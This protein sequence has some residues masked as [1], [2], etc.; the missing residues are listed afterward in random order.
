MFNFLI[1]SVYS[2]EVDVVNVES[3]KKMKNSDQ[4][5][6]AIKQLKCIQKPSFKNTE[7][8]Y[9]YCNAAIKKVSVMLCFKLYIMFAQNISDVFLTMQKEICIFGRNVKKGR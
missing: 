2:V 1:L 9:D 7:E 8:I 4:Q 6:T 5:E 3:G